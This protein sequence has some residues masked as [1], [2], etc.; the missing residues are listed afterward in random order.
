MV[1]FRACFLA[2]SL[3]LLGADAFS[4]VSSRRSSNIILQAA[5]T[6]SQQSCVMPRRRDFLATAFGTALLGNVLPGN[7]AATSQ[8]T[9]SKSTVSVATTKSSSSTE[10]ATKANSTTPA[11]AKSTATAN[12][13]PNP[14]DTK[15]CSDFKD[16]KEAK[17]WYDKYFPSYG[18]VAKL[19][20]NKDGIPCESLPGAPKKK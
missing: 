2:A 18:D 20:G 3:F 9:D 10:T 11:A 17:A 1:L 8:A 16:Y 12:G 7:A 13:L 15:N 5:P 4:V 14:G 6:D 19:D